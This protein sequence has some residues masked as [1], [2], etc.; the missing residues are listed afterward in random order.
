[1]RMNFLDIKLNLE[2][3]KLCYI[4]IYFIIKLLFV[5]WLNLFLNF[6]KFILIDMIFLDMIDFD[7]RKIIII[8]D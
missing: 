1:M 6:K 4:F 5:I 3:R 2:S 7:V 8:S